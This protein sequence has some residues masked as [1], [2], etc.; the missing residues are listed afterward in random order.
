MERKL[1]RFYVKFTF[2]FDEFC[3]SKTNYYIF[4]CLLIANAHLGV[5]MEMA[6]SPRDNEFVNILYYYLGFLC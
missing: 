3:E 1:Q 2:I 6:H 5:T 4:F